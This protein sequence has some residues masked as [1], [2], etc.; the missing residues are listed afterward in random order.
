[1]RGQDRRFKKETIYPG[2]FLVCGF[3]HCTSVWGRHRALNILP[4]ITPRSVVSTS[5]SLKSTMHQDLQFPLVLLCPGGVYTGHDLHIYRIT[6][7]FVS[8]H[9]PEA[10]MAAED[11]VSGVLDEH[12][13]H[14]QHIEADLN[15]HVLQETKKPQTKTNATVYIVYS[16]LEQK[17]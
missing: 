17:T 6:P 3:Q 1:M 7:T 12:A 9:S 8:L 13:V 2:I 11:V 5:A 10:G 14:R 16:F 15:K 4:L